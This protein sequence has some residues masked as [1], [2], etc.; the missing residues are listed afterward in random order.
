MVAMGAST[1]TQVG[2]NGCGP[3]V[4]FEHRVAPEPVSSGVSFRQLPETTLA[5][6]CIIVFCMLDAVCCHC[7]RQHPNM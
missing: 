1:R 6:V 5:Q 4:N 3:L 7:H 2:R